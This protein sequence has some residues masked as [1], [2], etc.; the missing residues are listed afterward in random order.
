MKSKKYL[1]VMLLIVFFIE[2]G[3]MFL[4]N[5]LHETSGIAFIAL[6]IAHNLKNRHFYANLFKGVYGVWCWLNVISI[7]F[8]AASLCLLL[9]SGVALSHSLFPSVQFTENF[10]WRSLHLT[11][12]IAALIFLSIHLLLHGKKYIHG[13]SMI[14]V[15][16]ITFVLITMGIFGMPY[17]DRWYHQ[18]KVDKVS[19]LQGEKV[20]LSGRV[21]TIY[22]SR[23]G[24]TDFPM[25]VDAVSG[26]S[27]MRDKDTLIGNAEMIAYMVQDVL[28]GDI[29]PISTVKKYPADYGATVQEAK[30]EFENGKFPTLNNS[31]V[32]ISDYDTI[33]LVYPLWW[34]TL[35]MAVQSFLQN[36]DLTDKVILPIVTHGGGG[37]G[38]S[39]AT[40]RQA[41]NA[42][43]EN[44]LSIYSSD[45]PSARSI[46][47]DYL[48]QFESKV[49]EN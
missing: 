42:K 19:L 41:T 28:G 12:A 33:V 38:E 8:F 37:S 35:P 26:A 17:L 31:S 32:T 34:H 10:N 11:A 4:P 25:D 45:I 46:I 13:K 47:F 21:L 24:N 29:L 22:F 16:V 5:L 20:K 1:D 23:V 15:S 2:L 30:A 40:L 43:V 36:Q 48:K 14:A 7:F 44:H 3:G 49:I 27:I 18:V 39:I 9:I 6:V